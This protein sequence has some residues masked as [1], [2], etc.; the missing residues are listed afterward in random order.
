M[1]YCLVIK[2]ITMKKFHKLLI[3]TTV[4]VFIF[5]WNI[6][7]TPVAAKPNYIGR[8]YNVGLSNEYISKYRV[9]QKD[10]KVHDYYQNMKTGYNGSLNWWNY[11]VLSNGSIRVFSLLK[12]TC[13]LTKINKMQ[14]YSHGDSLGD[15]VRSGRLG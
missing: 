10:G 7:S 9:F 8:W 12:E 3:T 6:H 14:C 5:G 2:E 13:A 1:S 15:L 4:I 11:Q